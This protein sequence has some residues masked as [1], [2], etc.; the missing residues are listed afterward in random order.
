MPL[1]ARIVR[2]TALP[3][4]VPEAMAGHRR[5]LES[6]RESGKLRVAGEF[7]DGDGFLEIFEADDLLE[8][9]DIARSSPLVRDGLSS[10]FVREWEETF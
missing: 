7:R 10:W 4:D 6:L 9:D 1:Y 5:H 8:A 2:I 3:A